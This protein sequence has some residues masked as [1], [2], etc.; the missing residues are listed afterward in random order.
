MSDI[1]WSLHEFALSELTEYEKNP[2]QLTETEY[3]Q[4]KTSLDKF[5]LIDKPIVNLDTT[6]TI[7]GGHQ[8]KHVL[9][10]EGAKTVTCWIPSR[11]LTEREVEELNIRLNKNTGGWDWDAL[12]NNFEVPDLLQWGFSEKELQL[13]GFDLDGGGGN[14][15]E[16]AHKTLA[17][18]FGVPPFSVLDARQGYWQDR[19]RA[20]LSLGLQSEL[21]RGGKSLRTRFD[22]W[23]ACCRTK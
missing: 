5:G 21:G 17:E 6:N 8:R 19:K 9:E 15:S 14:P 10:H 11:E 22:A 20:W 23:R 1:T 3:K 12:A 7:I 4:L 2:R 13:G 16:V 18:R